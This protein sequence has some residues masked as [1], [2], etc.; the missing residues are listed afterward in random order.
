[1][2]LWQ[3]HETQNQLLP[4]NSRNLM[5]YFNHRWILT[6]VSIY[7]PLNGEGGRCT[8]FKQ[9][10]L[11]YESK[12]VCFNLTNNFQSTITTYNSFKVIIGL[13]QSQ[14]KNVFPTRKSLNCPNIFHLDA[15]AETKLHE[16]L[17]LTQVDFM[18]TL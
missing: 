1:M 5:L 14:I 13:I 6:Q 4:L 7:P 3:A 2:A 11:N 10:F 9:I 12:L 18:V 15:E 8:K 17:T 16:S